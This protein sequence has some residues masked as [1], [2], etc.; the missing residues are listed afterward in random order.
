DIRYALF[1]GEISAF[2]VGK[3]SIHLS[4]QFSRPLKPSDIKIGFIQIQKTL[5]QKS[6]I[7]GKTISCSSRATIT[8]QQSVSVK[9][10]LQEVS[11][12]LG[13][14]QVPGFSQHLE[15]FGEP[16]NHESIPRCNDF[17]IEM[18]PWSLISYGLEFLSS[19]RNQSRNFNLASSGQ[20]RH[21]FKII[22]QVKNVLSGE[23]T[24]RIAGAENIA[25]SLDSIH[26]TKD[27]RFIHRQHTIN[28][29]L[30]PNVEGPL[31]FLRCTLYRKTVGILC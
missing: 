15:A 1:S 6:V 9:L 25:C 3:E 21:D 17:I 12:A 11:C 16:G 13:R 10:V 22:L 4:L 24:M 29:L 14:R 26:P 7:F 5:D 28:F 20:L 18:R 27:Q 30:T 2:G 8:P 19:C 31:S 23:F